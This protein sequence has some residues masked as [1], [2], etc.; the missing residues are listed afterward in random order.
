MSDPK[1]MFAGHP[2]GSGLTPEDLEIV[3]ARL[4]VREFAKG[5]EVS[6]GDET[7]QS[8]LFVIEGA[9]ELIAP[10]AD[11]VERVIETAR[12]G[13][14]LGQVAFFD[15][16]PNFGLGRAAEDTIC[17]E[18]SRAAADELNDEAQEAIDAAA[19]SE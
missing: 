10:I 16:K 4:E 14:S 3:A 8:I 7:A 15:Q 1:E 9:V 12:A 18:L 19:D 6:I 5:D 13:A 2:A 11:D 17:L